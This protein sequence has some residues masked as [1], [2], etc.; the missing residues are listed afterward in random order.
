MK[1]I[2][3]FGAFAAMLFMIACNSP[4]PPPSTNPENTN[5]GPVAQNK[6][7][8]DNS[9]AP[10]FDQDAPGAK[11]ALSVRLQ[12]NAVRTRHLMQGTVTAGKLAY[13]AAT[14]TVAMGAATGSSA[15]DPSLVGGVLLACTAAGNN[16]Q[17]IDN[18]VLNMDGSMTV[19]L[20]ANGT[21][22]NQIRCVA[23]KANALGSN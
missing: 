2:R 13:V 4:A 11:G 23:L 19:T 1:T 5:S 17:I 14:I 16:D 20:G 7:S 22:A 21:A 15:A 8:P 9:T 10:G 6:D 12:S 3:F 18:A